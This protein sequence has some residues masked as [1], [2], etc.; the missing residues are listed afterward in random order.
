MVAAHKWDIDG[1]RNAGLRTAFLSRP[2]EKG[3]HRTAD[4]ASDVTSDLSVSSFPDLADA[5]DC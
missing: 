1:A 4:H 3:P 5:L 2:L